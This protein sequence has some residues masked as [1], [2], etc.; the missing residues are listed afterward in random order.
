MSKIEM[1]TA[2]DTEDQRVGIEQGS[3]WEEVSTDED[4]HE[5]SQQ[6][7][8]KLKAQLP[9][10]AFAWLK[11]SGTGLHCKVREIQDF[12]RLL[13]FCDCLLVLCSS[14]MSLKQILCHDHMQKEC[15]LFI[16]SK[17]SL[18]I[19]ACL[20]AV[21]EQSVEELME[22]AQKYYEDVALP[23]LVCKTLVPSL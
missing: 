17:K 11:D 15:F 20:L 14:V 4:C 1:F 22:G 13:D 5:E 23:K 18:L 16:M 8:A 9:R 6:A 7:D 19:C 2:G 3:H 21:F 10:S 12:N